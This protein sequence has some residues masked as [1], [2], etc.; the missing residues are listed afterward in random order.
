MLFPFCIQADDDGW[1]H[2]DLTDLERKCLEAGFYRVLEKLFDKQEREDEI[3]D[4]YL[5]DTSR[6]RLVFT[7]LT[8]A[9]VSDKQLLEKMNDLVE[10]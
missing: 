9:R 2:F 6:R 8:R 7:W 4:C 10:Q 5:L 1:S 3:L